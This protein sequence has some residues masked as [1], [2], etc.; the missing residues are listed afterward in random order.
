MWY[1]QG[2]GG[3]QIGVKV[4]P[5]APESRVVGVYGDFL[6]VDVAAQP[7]K[8]KA[9]DALVKVLSKHF[10]VPRDGITIVH[11]KNQARKLVFLKVGKN[12][13]IESA[14]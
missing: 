7:E 10:K 6:K 3:M 14:D 5:G 13:L 8:G 2:K 1:Q 12:A 4:K 11:G 9:N